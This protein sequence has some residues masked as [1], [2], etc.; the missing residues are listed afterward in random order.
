MKVDTYLREGVAH[1]KTKSIEKG[2]ENR[3]IERYW[4]EFR[5]IIK[6][7]RG[8]DNEKSASEFADFYRI[9]HNFVRSHS[10]LNGR[11]LQKLQVCI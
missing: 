8:L 4:N 3:A 10:G 5:E 9:F 1:I 7:K 11:V 6:S 2:F